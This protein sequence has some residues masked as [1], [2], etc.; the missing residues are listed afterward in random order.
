MMKWLMILFALTHGITPK[1]CIRCK[2]FIADR[3]NGLEFSKCS[4]L[5]KRT[6]IDTNYLVTG[7]TTYKEDYW[8]CSTARN[9]EHLCGIDGKLFE[10]LDTLDGR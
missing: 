6:Y 1:L 7:K 8:Y 3:A 9:I 2:Y 4:A 5:P 10:E